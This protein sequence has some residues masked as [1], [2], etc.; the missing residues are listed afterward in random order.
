MQNWI[1]SHIY[2]SK[3]LF[4]ICVQS[5]GILVKIEIYFRVFTAVMF[6][7]NISIKPI[8]GKKIDTLHYCIVQLHYTIVLY[9]EM[10]TTDH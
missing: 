2:F 10:L 9:I 8:K 3:M 1:S 4:L 7:C 6:S 5:Q